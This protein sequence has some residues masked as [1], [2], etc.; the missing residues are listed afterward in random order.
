ML[1]SGLVLSV[2]ASTS[3]VLYVSLTAENA[4][5]HSPSPE[6]QTPWPGSKST[7]RC[8]DSSVTCGHIS[9][10][11]FSQRL[12]SELTRSKVRRKT[13]LQVDMNNVVSSVQS[14]S[15]LLS[16]DNNNHYFVFGM[17]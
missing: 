14:K 12:S 2:I 1:H 4:S 17:M 16:S 6:C 11:N 7:C 15:Y 9:Y 5:E 3:N 10:S 13:V 8:A